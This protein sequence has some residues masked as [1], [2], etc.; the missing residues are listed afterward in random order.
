MRSRYSA[1]ARGEVSYLVRTLHPSKRTL[2]TSAEL[3]GT[4][5]S[6]RW[7]GLRVLDTAAGGPANETGEVEFVAFFEDSGGKGLAR[8]GQIHERSTFRRRAGAWLYVDASPS[9][10]HDPPARNAPCWCDSGERYRR[11]HG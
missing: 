10:R 11:C 3:R 9:R 5:A 6:T 2:N 4:I 8:R 1:F 7:T